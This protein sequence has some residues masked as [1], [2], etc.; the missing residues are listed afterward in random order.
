MQRKECISEFGFGCVY[1]CVN[2]LLPPPPPPPW[3]PRLRLSAFQLAFTWKWHPVLE[4]TICLTTVMKTHR[5]KKKKPQGFAFCFTQ[6]ERTLSV[7]GSVTSLKVLSLFFENLF[8]PSL[9]FPLLSTLVWF[10]INLSSRDTPPPKK[11]KPTKPI[12]VLFS[13]CS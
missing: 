9:P 2:L 1:L 12:H 3:T 13:T 8:F 5:S 11:K 7:N 10:W 4:C 6:L